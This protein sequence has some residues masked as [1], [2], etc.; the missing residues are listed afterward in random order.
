MKKNRKNN[1]LNNKHIIRREKE[2]EEETKNIKFKLEDK[3][4]LKTNN[5]I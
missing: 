1:F 2:K 4:N 3:Y 5:I